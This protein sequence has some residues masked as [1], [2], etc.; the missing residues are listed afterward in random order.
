MPVVKLW[1]RW[2]L[3]IIFPFPVLVTVMV[4]VCV[5]VSMLPRLM[6]TVDADMSLC[7]TTPI[8]AVELLTV[9][10]LKVVA[11]LIFVL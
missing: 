3:P 7:R 5:P 4:M 1:A 2:I 8:A 9:R 11:P 6:F 10:I